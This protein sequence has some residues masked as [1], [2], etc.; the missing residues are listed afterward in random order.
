MAPTLQLGELLAMSGKSNSGHWIFSNKPEGTYGGNVW[1][2]ASI[3]RTH[4]YSIKESEGNRCKVHS[5]DIVH[6][7]T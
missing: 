2:V 1:D 4:R 6:M 7:R 3:L 5:G